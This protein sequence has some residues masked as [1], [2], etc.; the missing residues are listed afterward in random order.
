LGAGARINSDTSANTLT[1]SGGITGGA[2]VLYVGGA[3][4]TTVS[5][6]IT[7][8]GASQDSVVTSVYKDGDGTLTLSGAN[9]YTGITRINAGILLVSGSGTLG[10]GSVVRIASGASLTVNANVTVAGVR[11]IGNGNGGTVTIG[12][13]NT[14]TVNGANLGTFFQSSIN[15]TGGN[16]TFAGTGDTILSL[17]NAQGYSGT[18][19]VS[20]G[21]LTSSGAMSTA[22]VNIN[23]GTFRLTDGGTASSADINLASGGTF[24]VAGTT[25]GTSLGASKV[26]TASATG[27]NTT[28]TLTVAT[29]KDYSLGTGSL[30]FSAYGGGATSPL[31]V[32]GTGGN[33]NLNS[34]AITVTTSTQL[35]AGTYKL[36][37]KSGTANVT[38]TPGTLTM[39]G[40]GLAANTSGALSVS[41][42]ELLLTVTV[43][44][45]APVVT[46]ATFSGTVGTA[47]SESV[48]ASNSPTSYAVA[49]GTL[50]AG[51]TLNTSTGA[52]TGTPTTAASGTTVSI[53]ATNAGGTG[54]ASFTFN[55]AKGTPSITAAPTASAITFGQTLA[56]STLSGGTAS[57]AGSFAF[58][59]SSTAPN[60]GTAAQGVTFTPTDTA[61]YNTTTTTVNVTVSAA[62]LTSNQ[63]TLS[64]TNGINYTVSGPS[65]STFD[66]T[67]AGRTTNGLTNT[68]SSSVAPTGAGYYRVTADA[69]GNYSGS[70]SEDYYISGPVAVDE[71]VSRPTPTM[72][73]P[74]ATLLQNDVRIDASGAVQTNNLSI[75]AVA[76]G[77]GSPTVGLSH[78]AFVSFSPGGNGTETF[79]YTLTDS[80]TSKTATGTVTVVPLVWDNK[81]AF[82]RLNVSPVYDGFYTEATVT[83]TG[84]PNVTYQIRYKGE[85]N[86]AWRSA[87]GWYSE[88]G[89]FQVLIQE[90]GDHV[91]DWSGSMFFEATR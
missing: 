55:I 26:L 29:G 44:V 18:T 41:S 78:A 65:G 19:T 5:G 67:Y 46:G 87:G 27:A 83:F 45:S 25:S 63:I 91:S 42:G 6:A 74:R 79:T 73:I 80:V 82:E 30:A 11:E 53:S 2:N 69:T 81:F 48:S 72:N 16:L 33:L 38:G 50:P 54:S 1:L 17:Y 39:G 43:N 51:L 4:N 68:Y 21:I 23:G 52:I 62:S 9:A 85:M 59:T 88:S 57:V 20:S 15:G 3:G 71:T 47:F 35:A 75:T 64:S 90:E 84:T 36:I 7:G 14:L 8:A 70:N 60:A 22:T 61:N 24:D 34:R 40:S 89:T 10:S 76:A 32:S 13:G 28:A 66:I 12:N 56:S 37:A 58:T 31:T 77:T 86:Q 49:S